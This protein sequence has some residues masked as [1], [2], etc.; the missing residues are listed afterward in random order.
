MF[1]DS[2]GNDSAELGILNECLKELL[3]G[4]EEEFV[5]IVDWAFKIDPLC[6]ISMHGITERYLSA[7]KADT[8]GF[9][10]LLLDDL[11]TRVSM[12]FSRFVDDACYQ[13]EKCERNVRQTGVLP[14]IPRFAIL[15][16]RMEQY[17]QGQSRDL[18]DQAYLKIVSVMFVA[19][20]RTAQIDPKYVDI[21]LLENYAAFQNSL[22]DLANVVPT[23]AKFYHQASECYE[24]ACLRHVSMVIYIHFEKLFQFARRVEES[25]FN[26]PPEEIPFQIGMSKMD[27]RKV[28]KSS[29][30]GLD[31]IINAMYRKLQKNITAEELLPSLWDKC[32][33]EFLEKYGSF[34]E[35]VAK[36]YPTETVPSLV[37]V[38]D[39][40]SS[41]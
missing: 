2:S 10:H 1:H 9:V 19:L 29:L 27:L 31:K 15:A 14:Y 12:L 13:I 30:S 39:A 23:L 7:Q 11:E 4:L 8:A 5:S 32:K 26:I 41:L 38:R 16:S 3:D 37:E 25:M 20:E 18:I 17:I 24:Q 40:L 33:K 35:L 22:Y 6:C 28:V 34:V 36:I 21:V